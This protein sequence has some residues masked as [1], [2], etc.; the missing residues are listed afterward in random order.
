MNNSHKQLGFPS[1]DVNQMVEL[2]KTLMDLE[3][4]WIPRKPMHSMYIR[5]FSIAMDSKIG[6]SNVEKMKLMVV[7]SPVGPYYPRGFVPLRLYCDQMAVRAWPRG[8]G[9]KKVG[10]NYAP[11]IRIQRKGN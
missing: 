1:F 11:T 10:G 2:V 8:F 3:R 4:D 7:M 5:P 9:D 6:L